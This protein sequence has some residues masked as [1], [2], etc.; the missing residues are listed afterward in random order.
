MQGV[1]LHTSGE[2]TL[3]MQVLLEIVEDCLNLGSTFEEFPL[4]LCKE[5]FS[6]LVMRWGE[7]ESAIGL[8]YLL[9]KWDAAVARIANCDGRVLV[10]E[11]WYCPTVMDR[12]SCEDVGTKLSVI[13]DA[14]MQLKAVVFSL[15][16]VSGVGVAPGYMVVLSSDQPAY[17][18]HGRVHE[19][20]LR[21]A[22]QQPIESRCQQRDNSMAMLEKVLVVWEA[23]EVRV[24]VLVYP[25]VDLADGLL[26]RGKEVED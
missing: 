11:H 2:A 12:S 13:V 4:A 1:A 15:P 20:K 8:S 24:V 23:R 26:L 3:Q 17:L 6:L 9:V 7:Y 5:L 18:K 21:F 14:G 22:F 25:V 19:A 10:H 16:V